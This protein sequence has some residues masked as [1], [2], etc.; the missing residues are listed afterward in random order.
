MHIALCPAFE[1]IKPWIILNESVPSTIILRVYR[2]PFN[3]S[4]SPLTKKVWEIIRSSDSDS[5]VLFS[6]IVGAQRVTTPRRCRDLSD[7]PL[8]KSCSTVD[9]A[10]TCSLQQDRLLCPWKCQEFVI[11]TILFFYF[12]LWKKEY[13]RQLQPLSKSCST[14]VPPPA[15]S[16]FCDGK[17][18]LSC[19]MSLKEFVIKTLF[20]KYFAPW[21][22][23]GLWKTFVFCNL[24][25]DSRNW[26]W[27][28][29]SIIK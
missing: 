16:S 17:D 13:Q 12:A 26:E 18:W 29:R 27:G 9:G 7:E 19:E 8:S 11:K 10:T 20:P 28:C 23:N 15:L 5:F 6:C 22:K 25:T 14:V 1:S 2:F 3:I 24:S 21:K 4:L